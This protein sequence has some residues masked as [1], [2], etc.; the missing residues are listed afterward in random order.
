MLVT[1]EGFVYKDLG[2]SSNQ[3]FV[4]K[5]ELNWKSIR[6]PDTPDYHWRCSV[7]VKIAVDSEHSLPPLCWHQES[8]NSTFDFAAGDAQVSAAHSTKAKQNP[9]ILRYP[10]PSR[11]E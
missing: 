7:V 1:I 10:R 2:F 11:N 6:I 8:I 3:R 9:I 5:P 4:S